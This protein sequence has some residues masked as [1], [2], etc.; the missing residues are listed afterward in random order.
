MENIVEN[1]K[2]DF[3]RLEFLLTLL[4]DDNV[5]EEILLSVND[6]IHEL[7]ESLNDSSQ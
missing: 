4:N 6:E 1:N 7:M 2:Y 5:T 3:K